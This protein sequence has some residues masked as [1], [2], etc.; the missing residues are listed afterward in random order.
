MD[1]GPCVLS[2]LRDEM[3]APLTGA[4]ISPVCH[5]GRLLGIRNYQRSFARFL[6]NLHTT[7]VAGPTGR[8]LVGLVSAATVVMAL[9][10]LILWWTRRILTITHTRTLHGFLFDWHNAVGA[11]A[12]IVILAIGATGVGVAFGGAVDPLVEHVMNGA[13]PAMVMPRS[14]PVRAGTTPITPDTALAVASQALPGAFADVLLLPARPGG[15]YLAYLK[16][17]EDR[18]P[19]GRSHVAIDPYTGHV[20]AVD[21]MRTAGWGTW[22]ID[23]KRSI[24][25]GDLL[26]TPTEAIY[27]V[28]GLLLAMQALSGFLM[29]WLP[30]R[31][32]ATARREAAG[33]GRQIVAS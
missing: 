15:V 27:F 1:V 13:T 24:H 23:L 19:A 28:T 10:G 9:S 11:Y 18:T 33:T 16:F 21:D 7:L 14:V 20:L 17:P 5:T 8:V 30:R 6:H 26:G 3:R 29:W 4:R 22:L 31:R 2:N 25:T 12:S 32:R